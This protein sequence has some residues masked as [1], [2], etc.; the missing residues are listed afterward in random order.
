[1]V[2]NVDDILKVVLDRMGAV[3]SENPGIELEMVEEAD[4]L[5]KLTKVLLSEPAR[6][7]ILRLSY[8]AEKVGM[9]DGDTELLITLLR[10]N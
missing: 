9:V 1:M 5:R 3:G 7:S 10:D 6:I 8:L 2:K 4:N